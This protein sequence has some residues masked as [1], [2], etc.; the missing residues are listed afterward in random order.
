MDAHGE[1]GDS[2]NGNDKDV[3]GGS[4]PI[5]GAVT[6]IAGVYFHL[7]NCSFSIVASWTCLAAPWTR[8]TVAWS[9]YHRRRLL[10]LT[11]KEMKY[12]ARHGRDGG[13][14]SASACGSTSTAP[15]SDTRVSIICDECMVDSMEWPKIT[16]YRVLTE[17]GT[18]VHVDAEHKSPRLAGLPYAHAHHMFVEILE[19]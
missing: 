7:K 8:L 11:R 3:A 12:W 14:P 9:V 16:N 5:P 15:S 17:K 19:R 2:S 4:A 6:Y 1:V 13:V 18:P 10:A